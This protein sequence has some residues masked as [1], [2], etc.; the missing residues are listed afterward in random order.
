M[1]A[2][3]MLFP[4]SWCTMTRETASWKRFHSL[5]LL[6]ET[7]MLCSHCILGNKFSETKRHHLAAITPNV[8][9]QVLVKRSE[10][11]PTFPGNVK[12]CRDLGKEFGSSSEC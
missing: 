4:E 8:P 7:G 11:S 2:A 12:W 3:E 1:A 5:P 10:S 9:K 6:D